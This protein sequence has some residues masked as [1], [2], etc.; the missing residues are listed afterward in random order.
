VCSYWG[1]EE[2]ER[3]GEVGREK[4]NKEE[5]MRVGRRCRERERGCVTV[6]FFMI[7]LICFSLL[8]APYM[9]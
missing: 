4:K 3:G 7:S 9:L 6:T 5:E 1:K 8:C 2:E